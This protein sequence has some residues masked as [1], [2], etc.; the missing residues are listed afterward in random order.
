MR[1]IFSPQA[2]FENLN[3]QANHQDLWIDFA[4][5]V[6]FLSSLEPPELNETNVIFDSFG[7]WLS[8]RLGAFVIRLS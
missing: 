5:C 4:E 2:G 1:E 6:I 8:Q 3:M 7:V